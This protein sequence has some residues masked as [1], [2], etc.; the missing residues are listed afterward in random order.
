MRR[1]RSVVTI[2]TQIVTI[3]KRPTL[4]ASTRPSLPAS[5]SPDER[6]LEAAIAVFGVRGFEKARLQEIVDR[7]AVS[8]PLFY[9]RYENKAAIFEAAV[10][11]V[12]D[13]WRSALEAQSDC[14][15]GEEPEA[16]RRVFLAQLEYARSRPFL[17]RLLSR[18]GQLVLTDRGGTWDRAVASLRDLLAGLIQRGRANGRLRTDLPTAHLTDVLT[19]L[20]LSYANRQLLTDAAVPPRL[21]ASVIRTLLDGMAAD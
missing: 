15:D 10:D 19:E 1:R 8:K 4:S 11:R 13:D 16:I 21:A 12:F 9:R 3:H 5:S 2:Q 7:A 18:D 14:A 6:L 17:T 20:H